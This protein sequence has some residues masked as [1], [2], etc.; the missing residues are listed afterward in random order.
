M[1]DAA[2]LG[3]EAETFARALAG[4]AAGERVRAAYARFLAHDDAPVTRADRLLLAA[5]RVHPLCARATDAYAARFRKGGALR[6]RMVLLLALLECAPETYAAV[7][8]PRRGGAALGL[9]RLVWE[10]TAEALLAVA[11]T[12]VLGPLHVCALILPEPRA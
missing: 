11:A 10:G 7:D 4:C 12:L 3:R 5:A 1:A 6:R 8:A 2:L 9:A